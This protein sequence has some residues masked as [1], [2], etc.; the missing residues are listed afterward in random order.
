MQ[1]RRVSIINRNLGSGEWLANIQL[2]VVDKGRDLAIMSQLR[3]RYGNLGCH[4]GTETQ[5]QGA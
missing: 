4:R 3:S 5:D 2:H 1:A